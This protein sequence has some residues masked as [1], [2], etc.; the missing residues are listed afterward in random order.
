MTASIDIV[1]RRCLACDRQVRMG[2]VYVAQLS[3]ADVS[4][5]KLVALTTL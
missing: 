2:R 1:V 5:V 3:I 4:I